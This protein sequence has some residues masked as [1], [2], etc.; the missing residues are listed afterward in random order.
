MRIE[1]AIRKDHE[2]KA[3]RVVAVREVPGGL[4]AHVE[5][6]RNGRLACGR[7]RRPAQGIYDRGK[8]R[9]WRTRDVMT[10]ALWLLYRPSASCAAGAASGSLS[11]A[12]FQRVTYLPARQVRLPDEALAGRGEMAGLD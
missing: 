9:R 10:R 7:C 6:R 2:M 3:H 8:P 1:T 11:A 4:E 12:R 5:R